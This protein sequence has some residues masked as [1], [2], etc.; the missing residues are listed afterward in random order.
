ML[1]K[2]TS[3]HAAPHVSYKLVIIYLL[4]EGCGPFVEDLLTDYIVSVDS[5]YLLEHQLHWFTL[6]Y[7]LSFH[8][9]FTLAS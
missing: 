6:I 1:S 4:L 3:V 5:D 2:R 8:Q 7:G 9:F